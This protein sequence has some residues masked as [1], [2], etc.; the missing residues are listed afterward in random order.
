MIEE[1]KYQTE[2][3]KNIFE[4]SNEAI[5]ILEGERI[6]HCNKQAI[7]LYGYSSVEEM[8]GLTPWDLSPELQDNNELSKKSG[9]H[10]IS[11]T[12][13]FEN[14]VFEWVH[15]HKDGKLFYTEVSLSR[16]DYNNKAYTQASIRDISK[17]K[18]L[19]QQL[20]EAK[21]KAEE[22]TKLK[23]DFLANMSH[24][25]RNPLNAILGFSKMLAEDV[26]ISIGDR[27]RFGTLIE[28]NGK[29]LLFLINDIIDVSKI[30][31]NQ[32]QIEKR[33]VELNSLMEEL[34]L[35]FNKQ[36]ND[37]SKLRLKLNI[38]VDDPNFSI[39][40]DPNRIKQ[41]LSNL[42]SNAVK[43]TKQGSIEFG[44]TLENKKTIQFFVKDTGIGIAQEHMDSIFDRFK[45]D[46]NPEVK[47]IMGTGLG[48]DI[49]SRLVELLDG[50]IWAFSTL[51]KGSEFYFSI[52]AQLLNYNSTIK[53]QTA[54]RVGGVDAVDWSD[55]HILIADDDVINYE[56]LRI[57]L[58][59]TKVRTSKAVNG[60]E[61]LELL[62][63]DKSIDLMLLDIQM[64]IMNGYE[65]IKHIRKIK[66][67]MPVIAQTAVSLDYGTDS[68][69]AEM[70]DDFI[71]KPIDV[72]SLISKV[73]FYLSKL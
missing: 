65:A 56:L 20:L 60:K 72:K 44:Y 40:S 30:E 36:I 58:S 66:P 63:H 18:E 39:Y 22:S 42:L 13:Q 15:H 49:S 54:P 61:A 38:A 28:S 6:I 43:Y 64:P 12:T 8:I 34:F 27:K 67:E 24:D 33:K 23:T 29:N 71:S 21:E 51:H 55:F 11:K 17:R 31:A 68:G 62:E 5:L 35:S 7:S 9:I 41:I 37:S 53:K 16:F 70:F 10:M 1:K 26:D 57:I 47:K 4:Q 50:K 3:F 73:G 48:L 25:I 32:M 59:K 69:Q 45:R 52:P 14:P 46:N 19:Q 2:F